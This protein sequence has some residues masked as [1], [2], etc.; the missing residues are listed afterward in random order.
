MLLNST[1]KVPG[2]IFRGYL[3]C[4]GKNDQPFQCVAEFTH[5]PRPVICEKVGP[6]IA[7]QITGEPLG[8]VIFLQKE[9]DKLHEI[10]PAVS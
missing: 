1:L 10:L 6:R 9:G 4:F 7:G 3:V 8:L 2:D 5:V